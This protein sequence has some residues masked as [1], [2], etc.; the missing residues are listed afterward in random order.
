MRFELRQ[1]LLDREP[2]FAG[3]GQDPGVA[4]F[5]TAGAW[6]PYAG[7]PQGGELPFYFRWYFRTGSHGDF[8]YLVRLLKPQPVDPRVGIRDSRVAF[9]HPRSTGGVLTE[10]VEPAGGH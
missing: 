4:P 1:E 3:I 10:I 5:A 9:L 6:D 7:R 8:L 2:R